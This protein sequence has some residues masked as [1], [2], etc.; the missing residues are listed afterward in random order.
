MKLKLNMNRKMKYYGYTCEQLRLVIVV[1]T[2]VVLIYLI[3]G[4]CFGWTWPPVWVSIA[5][6]VS[7]LSAAVTA[8][9]NVVKENR[10]DEL[11]AL[12]DEM[13]AISDDFADQPDDG[14]GL[15]G[16]HMALPDDLASLPDDYKKCYD[17]VRF[18]RVGQLCC[19]VVAF[20]AAVTAI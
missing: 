11:D 13:K 2:A 18:C 8:F 17:S 16:A 9:I 12:K 19:L 10:Q 5:K 15:P 14:A 20:A 7:A 6:A 4:F 3:S 1:S